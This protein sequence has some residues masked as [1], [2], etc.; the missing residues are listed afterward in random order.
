[1]GFIAYWFVFA[2]IFVNSDKFYSRFSKLFPK[3]LRSTIIKYEDFKGKETKRDFIYWIAFV[4]ILFVITSVPVVFGISLNL[5]SILQF[6]ITLLLLFPTL[7]IFSR[8]LNVNNY[9]KKYL[10]FLII[11]LGF[12]I[13]TILCLVNPRNLSV[14]AKSGLIFDKPTYKDWVFIVWIVFT[15][16]SGVT[17]IGRV[18]NE[19]GPF[20]NF[21]SIISGTFDALTY[22]LVGFLVTALPLSV[23]RRIYRKF[24]K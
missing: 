9:S 2:L 11:P 20:I 4:F 5:V 21:A 18:I 7:A 16:L 12:I 15:A 14:N 1:M 6:T 8:R 22:P 10:L 13:P 19:G 24:Q 23:L 3:T 17:A